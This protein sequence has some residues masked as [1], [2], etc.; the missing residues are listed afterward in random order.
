MQ[1]LRACSAEGKWSLVTERPAPVAGNH[2][3]HLDELP[4]I[5]AFFQGTA[6]L[7]T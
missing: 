5:R 4:S 1:A 7:P 2:L 3:V 6:S